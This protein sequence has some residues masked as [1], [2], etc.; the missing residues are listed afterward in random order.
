MTRRAAAA[1]LAL[2]LGCASQP[3]AAPPADAASPLDALVDRP[4]EAS[5]DAPRGY[6]PE[7]F[8]PTAATRAYCGSR[9]ADAVEARITAML[10]ALTPGEKVALMHGASLLLVDRSW[11][12]AGSERLGIPG[13][14][15][16]DGPRGLSVFTRTTATA[17]P[18]AM[19]RGATWDPALEGR[20]GAAIATELRSLGADVLLAPTMNVLRHP[21]WGRAQE[22]YSEDTHHTGAMAVPFI[23][24]A[25]SVGVIASAKHFAANSIEDTRHR[26]D[27]R[28]DERTLREVY[29]PHFRRAVVEARVGSVMSAYNRVNGDW[30]DQSAHLLRDILKGEWGFAGFVESDWSSGTH[31]D[32]ASVRAGLDVEMPT[33]VNFRRL[34]AALE[35]GDI[36]EREIDASVR[37]VLRAQL[38]FG[39]D[40]RQRADDPSR[41]A[42][43]EHLAL[44]REVARRGM[45]LLRN[46]P[47]RG[48]PALPLDAGAVRRLVV[49]GRNADVE[50]LGDRGSS[51][52]LAG[53]VVTALEGIR[54]RMV[55]GAEVTH[56]AGA[57]LDA[58]AQAAVRAADAVV[59][60]TGLQA[61]D[62][63]EGEIGAGDREGL[64]L[65]ASEV[66]LIRAAAALNERVVVVLEGGGAILTSDWRDQVEAVLMAFYPGAMGGS[67][68]A[69]ILFG[70]AAP[71][72]RLPFSIPEREED[73]TPFDNVS[74]SVTYGY[75]HGYRHLARMGTAP[76]HPF[77]GGL[78]YTTF[79]YSGLSLSAATVRSGQTVTA[80]VTVTNRG[81]VRAV[82]TAQLYVAARGSRVERAPRDLRAFAQVDLGPGESRPVTLTLRAD[83]LAYW[84]VATS[85]WVLEPIEY[86]VIV[87]HDSADAGVRATVRGE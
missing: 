43:A 85:A 65:R 76:A 55:A 57:T 35:R 53:E 83:D 20:V 9:D 18:V 12:V 23:E 22:T 27:V 44:A 62:E 39:L 47:S 6:V 70:D 60:V 64:A 1:A 66:A 51:N 10:A 5:V 71:S 78:S 19:M 73:L 63:G 11:R 86:E 80:T 49:L 14:R 15:M 69:E 21:R 84:D 33:P 28:M 56:V 29:L 16:L 61:D 26:V 17:F 68:L 8:T 32:V 31:G 42:S 67:A 79:G 46:E 25:Q 40:E 36:A 4:G 50:N 72:G 37:R 30:C 58:T 81:A 77:G 54:A 74:P 34:P 38:C 13:L 87:G 41:R 7:P 45:V 82:E 3:P 24:G 75:L 2:L 48:A 52:V 59:V